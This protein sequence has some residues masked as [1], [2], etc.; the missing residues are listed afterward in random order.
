M[1]LP[2]KIKISLTGSSPAER[3]KFYDLV[4]RKLKTNARKNSR[5]FDADT[6]RHQLNTGNGHFTSFTEGNR[7]VEALIVS[8][9]VP[10]DVNGVLDVTNSQQSDYGLYVKYIGMVCYLRFW[11]Y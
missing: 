5:R 9:C 10:T 8:G 11:S 4:L 7:L 6:V 3:D 1:A 2:T